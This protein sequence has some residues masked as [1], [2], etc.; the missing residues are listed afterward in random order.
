LD[1]GHRVYNTDLYI[2]RKGGERKGRKERK[3]GKERRKKRRERERV[4]GC[5]LVVC[6]AMMTENDAV[7]WYQK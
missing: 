7:A 6:Q 5:Y 4:P 1:P 3:R 2:N